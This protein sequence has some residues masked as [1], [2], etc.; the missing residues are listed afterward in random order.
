MVNQKD[1]FTILELIFVIVII[2]ILA[3][4]AV[5][6]LSSTS[7]DAKISKLA[8]NI[9]TAKTEI[10][11][12]IFAKGKIPKTVADLKAVS[13]TIIELEK[14]GDII[15]DENST[16]KRVYIFFINKYISPKERCKEIVL[17][18]NDSSNI[19]LSVK[20]I[21]SNSSICRGINSIIQDINMTI[22]GN[23]VGF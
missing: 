7:A 14:S 21:G 19:E 23:R 1:G 5:P 15:L 17:N 18:Y 22:A 4:I 10:A 12:S 20:E 9:Q 8:Y 2:G 11:T 13:N 6:K 3:V 16:E